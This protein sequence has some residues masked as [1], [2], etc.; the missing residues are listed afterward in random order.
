MIKLKLY[1]DRLGAKNMYKAYKAKNVDTDITY[2]LY[3]TIL[4]QFNKKLAVKILNGSYFNMGH[5]LG[6]IFIKKIKR[7]PSSKV[8]NWNETQALWKEL[9]KKEGF[10]YYTDNYYYRWNWEKRK[11]QVKN[12]SVYKFVPTGGKRGL[13]RQLIDKLKIDPFASTNYKT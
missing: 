13:K 10:V 12:K 5:R 4:E 2:P 7:T 6:Y 1:E 11:A 9:G 3:R 8:I